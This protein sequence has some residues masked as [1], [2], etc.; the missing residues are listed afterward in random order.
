MSAAPVAQ[1]GIAVRIDRLVVETEHAAAV[2]AFALH[3]ALADAVR[4]V[5]DH[6]GVPAAWHRGARTPV[7]VLDDFAWDGQGAEPGLARALAVR[8]YEEALAPEAQA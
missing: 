2:D 3:R 1:V 5:V 8:L 6:R 4:A 7:A